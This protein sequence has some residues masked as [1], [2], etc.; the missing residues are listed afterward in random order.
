[1]FFLRTGR[2]KYFPDH[3][4]VDADDVLEEARVAEATLWRL[5][6]DS[7]R[8]LRGKYNI[9]NHYIITYNDI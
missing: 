9:M 7:R 5:G 8:L 4:P 2:L 3:N 6:D 1:M